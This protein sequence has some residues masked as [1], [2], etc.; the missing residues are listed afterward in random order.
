M[1]CDIAV[2][3]KSVSDEGGRLLSKFILGKGNFGTVYVAEVG[4]QKYALKVTEG[5]DG[6]LGAV[7][8]A[9]Q[10]TE[11]QQRANGGHP[12]I[13]EKFWFVEPA[14]V[15]G[16]LTSYLVL[17]YIGGGSLY[18]LIKGTGQ[19][20]DRSSS[21]SSNSSCVAFREVSLQQRQLLCIQLRSA[22]MHLHHH[23]FTHRD[24]TPRNIMVVSL[25]P[26]VIKLIDLGM[27]Q[28]SKYSERPVPAAKL[29]TM[30]SHSGGKGSPVLCFDT[31]L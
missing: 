1:N 20:S 15:R 4:D 7:N 14:Y 13:V 25:H 23:G 3:M 11:L 18:E 22:L 8:E 6:Q 9:N 21:S 28:R 31:L 17:E 27:T 26:L 10:L 24:V 30:S 16:V 19:Y 12:H 29:K 5:V 2:V